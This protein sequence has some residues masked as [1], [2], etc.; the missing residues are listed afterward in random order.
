M[1]SLFESLKLSHCHHFS[2]SSCCCYLV[3]SFFR[4]SCFGALLSVSQHFPAFVETRL[5]HKLFLC[6]LWSESCIWLYYF[7]IKI[8]PFLVSVFCI[9]SVLLGDLK[10]WNST[11]S[12]ENW[13]NESFELWKL[14]IAL[15]TT[16]RGPN[17]LVEGFGKFINSRESW[18]KSEKANSNTKSWAIFCF[19]AE[20]MMMKLWNFKEQ[21]FFRFIFQWEVR[22]HVISCLSY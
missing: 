14:W 13:Q 11:N 19:F 21:S 4:D 5:F 15:A 20:L 16:N 2:C 10:I 1:E 8:S 3:A 22:V 7:E 18:K 6:K 9:V 12:D 17:S